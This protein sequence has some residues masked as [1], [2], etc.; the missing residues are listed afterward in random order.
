MADENTK[1]E[2]KTEEVDVDEEVRTL[3]Y[4]ATAEIDPALYWEWRATI[5]EMN[6]AKEKERC[7]I[8]ENKLQLLEIEYKKSQNKLFQQSA[9]SATNKR[10]EAEKEC[11]RMKEKIEEVVGFSLENCVIDDITFE[12]RKLSK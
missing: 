11:K 9:S 6:V 8:I 7:K 2:T 10:K 3:E 1:P 5:E 4:E 12:V